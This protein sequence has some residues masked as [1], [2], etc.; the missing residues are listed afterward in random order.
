MVHHAGEVFVLESTHTRA[1][2]W[3]SGPC[4]LESFTNLKALQQSCFYKPTTRHMI[5]ESTTGKLCDCQVAFKHE[6]I[7]QSS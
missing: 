5:S 2:A 1:T 7:E 3:A 6:K 4:Q